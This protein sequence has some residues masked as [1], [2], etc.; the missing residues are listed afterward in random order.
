EPH[1]EADRHHHQPVQAEEAQQE[2]HG[3]EERKRGSGFHRHRRLSKLR[4]VRNKPR[5]ATDPYRTSWRVSI[6]PRIKFFS[7]CIGTEK[8]NTIR[9][10][11]S[12]VSSSGL[13]MPA[14][15]RSPMNSDT[16]AAIIWLLTKLLT[17]RPI[18]RNI[19]PASARPIY[20]VRTG[21]GSIR[22]S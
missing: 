15:N 11:N 8:K 19:A 10:G 6:K 7:K 13:H 16:M 18:D 3:S 12:L 9:Y 4:T 14:M 1:R 17:N 20:V 5:S 22:H 2:L 21:N